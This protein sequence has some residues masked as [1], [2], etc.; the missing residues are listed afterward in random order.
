MKGSTVIVDA[1]GNIDAPVTTT[2]ATFSGN[3]TLGDTSAD[4]VA[5][6]GTTTA[7]APITVGVDD[8]GHDVKLFGATSGKYWLWDESAD[9]MILVGSFDQTGNSQLT[10]TLTVGV[11]DTGHDVKFFGATS[12]A[13][14]LWDESANKLVLGGGASADFQT[15]ISVENNV[16]LNDGQVLGVEEAITVGSPTL[17]SY[18]ASSLDSS[19]G[20]ITG[21]LGAGTSIGQIKTIVMTEA[22]TSS[23]ISITNHQTSDPEVATFDAVDETG[24]FMWTGTEWV[25]IFATCTFV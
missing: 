13:F 17:K 21:T 3:T 5:I 8:T 9:K 11:D 19:G 20:A 25:T 23:T 24:V 6:N 12:G 7:L 1:D 14:M 10:G 4:A 2:N 18:G 22:S 16:I 15:S